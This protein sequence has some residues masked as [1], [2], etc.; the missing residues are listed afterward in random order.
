MRFR[1]L[2]GGRRLAGEERRV[3]TNGAGAG[4]AVAVIFKVFG[5]NPQI[6]RDLSS[7]KKSAIYRRRGDPACQMRIKRYIPTDSPHVS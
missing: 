6:S 1:A 2:E 3:S 7:E 5:Y 4:G